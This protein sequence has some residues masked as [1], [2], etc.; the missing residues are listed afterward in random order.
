LTLK[1]IVSIMNIYEVD[2]FDGKKMRRLNMM[3]LEHDPVV[4]EH[5]SREVR[6][7]TNIARQGVTIW[8]E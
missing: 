2:C 4:T 5:G 8:L 7:I 3:D 6:A 1:E